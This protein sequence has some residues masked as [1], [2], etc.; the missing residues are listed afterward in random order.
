MKRLAL[1]LLLAVTLGGCMT[2][3]GP[4]SVS[5]GE[6]KVFHAP[7]YAVRGATQYDQDWTDSTIEGGVGACR[8]KRP[9]P[10]PAALNGAQPAPVAKKRVG[11]VKRVKAK[12]FP[13]RTAPAP[14]SV[15]AAPPVAAPRNVV[16]E[17]LHPSDAK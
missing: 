14:Q 5:R 12:L 3:D 9:A 17:L 1:P 13:A 4:G 11:W 8:W 16:D 15:P 2:T 10:R 6:C 7:K